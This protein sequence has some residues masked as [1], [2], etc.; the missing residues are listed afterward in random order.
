MKTEN[1][2]VEKLAMIILMGDLLRKI[3]NC[4]SFS[5]MK[6]K[7]KHNPPTSFDNIFLKTDRLLQERK[8]WLVERRFASQYTGQNS[9]LDE[10]KS[11]A[12]W[13]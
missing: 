1:K 5:F 3:V 8:S 6:E 4:T 2:E 10:G 7:W 9:R 12:V 11:Q 13:R